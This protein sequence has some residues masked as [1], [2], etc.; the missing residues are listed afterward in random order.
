LSRQLKDLLD[1]DDLVPIGTARAWIGMGYGGDIEQFEVNLSEF[2]Q[3]LS[4]THEALLGKVV[5]RVRSAPPKDG[6]R[7]V[8]LQ[9]VVIYE[10]YVGPVRHPSWNAYT[11]EAHGAVYSFVK[12]IFDAAGIKASAD[13]MLKQVI[14]KNAKI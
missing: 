9:C 12:S 5:P 8:A 13:D 6:P 14:K 2:L 7:A 1:A 3:N 4:V 11:S 10:E